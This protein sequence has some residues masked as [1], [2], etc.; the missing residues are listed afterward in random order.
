LKNPVP[1]LKTVETIAGKYLNNIV[2]VERTQKGQSTYV[3]RIMTR[4]ETFYIR[5]LPEDASFAAEVLVH[6]ILLKK[7]VIVPRVIAWEHRN[8]ETGLSIMITEEIPGVP[9]Q[10]EW[11]SRNA[12][13][14]LNEAGR[15]ITLVHEVPV[16]GFGWIDRNSYHELK[17]V[18]TTFREF[19]NEGL[20]DSLEMLDRFDFSDKEKTRISGLVEK[21]GLITDTE[22]SV[23]IHGDFDTS[24][25]LHR[26]G[27]YTGMIDFGEIRGCNPL[28][29]L[30]TC[31]LFDG[32]KRPLAYEYI[33]EGYRETVRLS[34]NDLYGV[35][36]F[37]L[38]RT[39]IGMRIR[40]SRPRLA[41]FF[42]AR[43]RNQLDRI[44]NL[45]G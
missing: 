1:E 9:A 28:A 31:L 13:E 38:Y 10:D 22:N 27:K 4:A 6:T 29:D 45:Y 12:R 32:Q 11:P 43:A 39:V 42:Y 36:L 24:Q 41:D 34:D 16:D 8:E 30:A 2:S 21:A 7:G 40:E 26:D 5:F 18:N 14:I 33:L 19:F 15:Q 44:S 35:E 37:V 20:T 17:G 23:L 25:I 3:F